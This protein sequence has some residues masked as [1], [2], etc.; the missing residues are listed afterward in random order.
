MSE[1]I[2]HIKLYEDWAK[3]KLKRD[4]LKKLS[5]EKRNNEMIK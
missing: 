1:K 2:R 3:I 5:A 4:T